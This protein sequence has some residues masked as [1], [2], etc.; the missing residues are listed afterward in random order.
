M[1]SN[2][3]TCSPPGLEEAS[4]LATGDFWGPTYNATKDLTEYLDQVAYIKPFID[5]LEALLPRVEGRRAQNL[6]FLYSGNPHL[7]T[8]ASI[9]HS[10]EAPRVLKVD[11]IRDGASSDII[12]FKLSKACCVRGLWP[13]RRTR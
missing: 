3:L 10:V 8:T 11:K 6:V 5:R 1:F 2:L 7:T 9:V 4:A 12:L 13:I